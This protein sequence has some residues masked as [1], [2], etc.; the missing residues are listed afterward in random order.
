MMAVLID[1]K[2]QK[3]A[4]ADLLRRAAVSPRWMT[5]F[6]MGLLLGLEL[7]SIAAGGGVLG[8]FVTILTHLVS[9][10]LGAG[11]IL[12]CMA[13]R[14]GERAEFLALFDGFALVGR[15]IGLALL[16]AVF[17]LLW[18][19]LFILP[20]IIAAYR[21]RFAV[22]NL[23]ENP[24]V[25][26]LEALRM[27]KWQSN[28]YKFQ[29]FALDLS[30]L[31]WDLLADLP[32]LV[33]LWTAYVKAAEYAYLYFRGAIPAMPLETAAYLPVSLWAALMIAS[34]W[35]LAY[36]ET[37]KGSSGVGEGAEGPGGPA[38]GRDPWRDGGSGGFGGF[39]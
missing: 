29:L 33:F 1:R 34:L 38:Q 18:S 15:L 36:F 8:N 17:I 22:Y 31:G 13:V 37:A 2:T 14:R 26:I 5:V 3:Q 12:Y 4:A 27:S 23:L 32:A 39:S 10:V 28:G 30:Y 9:L 25:G 21:Y 24:D 16:E 11:F 20:G 6:Y 35:K 19:M 7:L